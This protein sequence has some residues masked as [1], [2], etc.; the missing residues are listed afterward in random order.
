MDLNPPWAISGDKGFAGE[1]KF[2]VFDMGPEAGECKQ[3]SSVHS[4]IAIDLEGL[5]LLPS[6]AASIGDA[7][8]STESRLYLEKALV[9]KASYHTGERKAVESSAGA[10]GREYLA[11]PL[12]VASQTEAAPLTPVTTPTAGSIRIGGR[13]RR[14][15]G[16]R[17]SPWLDPRRV[18][19][20]F[21]TLSSMG[22]L[23]LLYFTLFMGKFHDDDVNHQ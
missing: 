11:V 4:F 6:S 12:H 2:G 13:C 3:T 23:I 17:P 10:A 5:S 7:D 9:R 19:V 1:P 15:A 20:F 18:L 14:H 8:P 21:A 16:R 22:T